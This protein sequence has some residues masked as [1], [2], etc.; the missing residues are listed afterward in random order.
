MLQNRKVI[1]AMFP[2]TYY[3]ARGADWQQGRVDHAR[4]FDIADC[5]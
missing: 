5:R 1:E 2:I 3:T 4:Y